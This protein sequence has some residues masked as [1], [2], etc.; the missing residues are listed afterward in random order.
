METGPASQPRSEK[1]SR[2]A[3]FRLRLEMWVRNVQKGRKKV[4]LAEGTVSV[5]ALRAE[6]G[7]E[8]KLRKTITEALNRA[9]ENGLSL[10]VVRPGN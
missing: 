7:R 4:L 6:A 9:K 10:W 5:K 1:T 8:I 3:K 2:K